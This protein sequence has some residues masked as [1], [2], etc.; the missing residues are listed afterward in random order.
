LKRYM[1]NIINN[2]KSNHS[3]DVEYT[4]SVREVLELPTLKGYK[5]L[6]GSNGLENR[7]L[8]ITILETPTGISW[9]QGGEFLLTAGY[10]FL[11]NE[12]HKKNMLIDAKKKR[13]SA[14]AIKKDRYFGEISEELIQQA[15]EFRI[16]LIQIPYEVIYTSTISSFYDMLFFRKHEYIL[17]LNE[18]YEKLLNLSFENKDIDGIIYSLSNLLNSSV[19][20]LDNSFDLICYNIINS[21]AFNRSANI[22]PFNKTGIDFIKELK[23]PVYNMKRDD[24]FISLYPIMVK[25]QHI[26]YVYIV[27]KTPLD[28]LAQRSIEYGISIIALKL[29]QDQHK[30]IIQTNINKTLV[31][32]MLNSSELPNEFYE[33]VEFNLDW[34]KYDYIFGICIKLYPNKD[35]DSNEN[36]H[37]SKSN[38]ILSN[39]FKN[40]FDNQNYLS[41]HRDN[42]FYIFIKYN[43]TDDFHDLLSR[44]VKSMEDYKHLFTIAIGVAK[45][46]RDIRDIKKLY[47]ES[48]LAA[49]FSN[50]DIVFY[51]SLDTIKLLYPL[52]EDNEIQNYYEK[53]IKAL[54]KYDANSNTN[55]MKT[56]EYYFKYNFKKTLV[57]EKLFIHV[58][59]LRYRLN[60]I[61][62]I[63]GYSLDDSEGIFALQMGLKL[64]KL[65]KIQ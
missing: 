61:E 51:D 22:S 19:F 6:G 14:I 34:K 12:N 48:K 59:T 4:L 40:I 5:L 15:N 54:E 16:P 7:C 60:R 17:K 45:T 26:A 43:S 32:I 18:I 52:K 56:L 28:R 63:T 31:D 64:K 58:E 27:K 23:G 38:F 55:L 41:T 9:L 20:L 62:E 42:E 13:V 3:H 57:A 46:Y 8:H 53:T 30:N 29:E 50:N 36:Y 35:Y 37:I 65:I 39:I 11:H 2:L 21:C 47:E 25:N 24:Y 10:A 44:L 49:L 33:N 1:E